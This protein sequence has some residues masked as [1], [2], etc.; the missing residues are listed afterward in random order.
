VVGHVGGV[1]QPAPPMISRGIPREFE[2]RKGRVFGGAKEV[3]RSGV[4]RS[5]GARRGSSS[6]DVVCSKVQCDAAV[7]GFPRVH[8]HGLAE[9][10]FL[11]MTSL[12]APPHALYCLVVRVL[13]ML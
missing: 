10:L 9:L 7:A 3:K 1:R 5:A 6:L 11:A 13:V 12:I 8:L 2:S 4:E